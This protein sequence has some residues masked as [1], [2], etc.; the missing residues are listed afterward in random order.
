MRQAAATDGAVSPYV[1][2]AGLAEARAG[3]HAAAA[4]L[5]QRVATRDD[6]PEAW[7]NLAAEQHLLGDDA[8]AL[9]SQQ[10]AMRLGQQ[11]VEVA[12]PAGRLALDLG[13]PDLAVAA[14]AKAIGGDST[15]A[16]DPWFSAD[17]KRHEAYTT[18]LQMLLRDPTLDQRW[19]IAMFAG[20]DQ[21]A[22]RL[23]LESSDPELNSTIVGAWAGE[24]TSMATLLGSCLDSATDLGLVSWCALVEHHLGDEHEADRYSRL[25]EGD[26]GVL[27][28]AAGLRRAVPSDAWTG[29]TYEPGYYWSVYTYREWVPYD[30]LVPSLVH[31]QFE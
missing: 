20:D 31:V 27:R 6:L 18:A 22:K 11:H 10:R 16:G 28:V 13:R 26:N 7:L 24:P 29:P 14:F 5:F 4:E 2:A 9:A 21:S 17:P 15:L 8:A 30:I 23:A 12:L 25:A 1:F 19:A 3:D